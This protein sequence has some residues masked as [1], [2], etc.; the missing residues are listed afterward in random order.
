M[1]ENTM[2]QDRVAKAEKSTGYDNMADMTMTP[3]T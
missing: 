3:I 2:I 1:I